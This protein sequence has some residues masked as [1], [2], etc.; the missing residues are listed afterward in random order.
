MSAKIILLGIIIFL[1]IASYYDIRFRIIPNLTSVG[2]IILGVVYHIVK[3]NQYGLKISLVGMIIGFLFFLFLYIFKMMG[4]GDVKLGTAVGSILGIKIIPAIV[5]IVFI[6]GFIALF[7][8]II[9]L[10][11]ERINQKKITNQLNERS[12]GN[13]IFKQSVP[14]GLAI[15]MGTILTLILY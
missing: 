4:A 15:S 12:F 10:I 9:F 5:I 8:I 3:N 7:Q 11:K 13:K 6:G 14:Y 1:C 2:I